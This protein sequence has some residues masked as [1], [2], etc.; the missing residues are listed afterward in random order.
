M[1]HMGADLG[2]STSCRRPSLWIGRSIAPRLIRMT[3]GAQTDAQA[4]RA[5]RVEPALGS[6]QGE[7]GFRFKLLDLGLVMFR[8]PGA[9]F[10]TAPGCQCK[11]SAKLLNFGLCSLMRAAMG[12][13]L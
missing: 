9:A 13:R 4:A 6:T 11:T 10:T 12:S 5:L 7:L 2:T 8:V 1:T 3:P